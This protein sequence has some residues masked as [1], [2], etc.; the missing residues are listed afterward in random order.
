MFTFYIS[1]IQFTFHSFII[2]IKKK[3]NDN[4]SEKSSSWHRMDFCGNLGVLF[5]FK[6]LF[7]KFIR[8]RG[9]WPQTIKVPEKYFVPKTVW[10]NCVITVVVILSKIFGMI[11][12]E[13]DVSK[14]WWCNVCVLVSAWLVL[15]S[16]SFCK[17]S[18]YKR[19]CL[20]FSPLFWIFDSAV[21]EHTNRVIF[22]EDDDIA[23]VSDGRLSIHRIKR[24]AGDR[25]A[26]A[27]QTLQ[28]ELQQIMK[29]ETELCRH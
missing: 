11:A 7:I 1:F 29:G 22:L 4:I 15:F 9:C 19:K 21:I 5:W 8:R 23:A 26:R 24:R 14:K 16:S 13:T 27:I 28:M 17:T 12:L 18:L 10:I 20:Q 25:P 2:I 3:T 6:Y